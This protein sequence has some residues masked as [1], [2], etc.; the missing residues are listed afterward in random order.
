MGIFGKPKL[1][2]LLG[3]PLRCLVCGG[4]EFWSRE[5]KLN[6]TGAEFLGLSWANQSAVGLICDACGYVH[7]FAG[8]RPELWKPE[9]GYPG[10]AE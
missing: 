10:G 7:E 8:P 4:R 3:R 6:S 9:R 5:V 1:A 2:T